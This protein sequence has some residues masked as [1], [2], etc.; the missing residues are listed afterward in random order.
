MK[1]ISTE[2]IKT[3]EWITS[4]ESIIKSEWK[5]Y[6]RKVSDGINEIKIAESIRKME[7]NLFW[8]KVPKILN[9]ITLGESISKVK[10]RII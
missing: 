6:H 2:S 9:E 1:I 4:K 3:K 10:W 7:W 8:L 5:L